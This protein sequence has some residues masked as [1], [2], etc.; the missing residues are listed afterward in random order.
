MYSKDEL[1]A[2]RLFRNCQY[3]E[4]INLYGL[5]LTELPD[6]KSRNRVRTA[7][8]LC[9]KKLGY[10]PGSDSYF[11]IDRALVSSLK[12]L[13]RIH[14]EPKGIDIKNP[15]LKLCSFISHIAQ[16]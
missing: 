7:I 14:A 4:A 9:R 1:A 6:E 3:E 15:L 13:S 5:V 2:D 11:Q 16:C 10:K 8:K 12:E